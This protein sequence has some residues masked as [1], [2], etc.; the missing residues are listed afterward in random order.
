MNPSPTSRPMITASPSSAMTRP[1]SMPL[2]MVNVGRGAPMG[3]G[4]AGSMGVLRGVG[5][6]AD[7]MRY[8]PDSVAPP[9]ATAKVGAPSR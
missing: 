1:A 9:S 4:R 8:A 2:M 6:K 5:S 3:S 7:G